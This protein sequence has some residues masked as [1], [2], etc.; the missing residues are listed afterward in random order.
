TA[1]SSGDNLRIMSSFLIL[2]PF[3][4]FAGCPKRHKDKALQGPSRFVGRVPRT[5]QNRLRIV[6]GTIPARCVIMQEGFC[7]LFMRCRSFTEYELR[8]SLLPTEQNSTHSAVVSK[9]YYLIF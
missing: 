7:H 3:T 2:Y 1:I 5:R 4:C 8:L 6:Q 9:K